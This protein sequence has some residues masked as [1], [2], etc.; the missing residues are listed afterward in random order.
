M[1]L[2]EGGLA[3]TFGTIMIGGR[4]SKFTAVR[5]P[6]IA[7]TVITFE[8]MLPI[9]VSEWSVILVGCKM[10]GITELDASESKNSLGGCGHC[11]LVG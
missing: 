1:D 2:F 3:N 9:R 7:S 6:E 5:L 8:K 10:Y 4:W 11:S